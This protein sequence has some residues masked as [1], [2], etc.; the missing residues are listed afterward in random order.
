MLIEMI[1]NI[2]RMKYLVLVIISVSFFSCCRQQKESIKIEADKPL[3]KNII[4]N[5]EIA[6]KLAENIWLSLYGDEILS[7]KPFEAKLIN[8]SIWEVKGTGHTPPEY[9]ENGVIKKISFGGTPY[10]FIRKDDCKVIDVYYT[11]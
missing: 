4:S 6:V 10:I 3:G 8:D 11:K 2:L 5:K 9:D 7:S 1:K